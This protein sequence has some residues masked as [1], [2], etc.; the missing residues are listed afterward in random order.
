MTSQY[1]GRNYKAQLMDY[2]YLLAKSEDECCFSLSE[3]E[4]QIILANIDYI[5]WKTRYIP[6]E[7]DIDQ[8]VIDRWRDNLAR[9]LMSGCCP[10]D[11]QIS[12]YT[13]NGIY[14]TSNDGG[15]TWVDN[16]LDDPRNDGV[17]APPLGGTGD[18]TRCA[19]ADNIREQMKAFRQQAIDLLTAGTTVLAII[20][21]LI[22]ALGIILGLSGVAVGIS[23]MLFGLAAQLLSLTPESVGEQLTDALMNDYR[24]IVFCHAEA[25]GTFTE[26]GWQAILADVETLFTGF[27][28]SFF[29]GLTAALGYQ[30]LNNAAAMGSA[31]ADDCGDCEC[32]ATCGD[33]ELVTIGTVLEEGIDGFGR[34]YLHI[35]SEAFSTFQ[36]ISI[37][38]YGQASPPNTCCHIFGWGL[39]S[40]SINSSGYT[41]CAG[42]VHDPGNPETHDCG[43][44]TWNTAPGDNTTFVISVTFGT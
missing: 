41:D 12:R 40:G 28:K 34:R 5:G 44:A 18:A 37:G 10:D 35:Q 11:D 4:V 33:P 19:A 8:N 25:D 24:C 27:P 42:G 9:K 29:Y 20:A 3:R 26:D 14:Q 7:T 16:P 31:T 32:L 2:D 17:Q 6:T 36:N 23:V 21:A 43:H 1:F 39:I 13:A 15:E 38:T 22:G 30:G